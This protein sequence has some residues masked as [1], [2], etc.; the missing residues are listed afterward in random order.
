MNPHENSKLNHRQ[1]GQASAKAT[2]GQASAAQAAALEF[3]SPEEMLRQ[4]A[5]QTE[6]PDRVAERLRDS[7]RREPPRPQG[8]LRRLLGGS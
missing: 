1:R 2:T 3:S 7:I 4:D 6:V 8:W 5:A